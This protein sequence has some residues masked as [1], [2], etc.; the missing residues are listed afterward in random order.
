MAVWLLQLDR[1]AALNSLFIF[2]FFICCHR[3]TV[4]MVPEFSDILRLFLVSADNPKVC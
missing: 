4:K 1:S 2:I 3:L